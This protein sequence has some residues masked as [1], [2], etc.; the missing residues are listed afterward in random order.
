MLMMP[1]MLKAWKYNCTGS[2]LWIHSIATTVMWAQDV[3][4]S[5]C[6]IACV[7]MD[8]H[9]SLESNATLS[10]TCLTV[11]ILR[12]I[13][14][15]DRKGLEQTGLSHWVAHTNIAWSTSVTMHIWHKR[16]MS[17]ITGKGLGASDTLI[18]MRDQP[19]NRKFL[20]EFGEIS[21]G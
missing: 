20:V 10:A 13:T 19:L 14:D 16:N 9:S 17:V 21:Q 3:F 5:G 18:L 15:T 11:T 1:F 7:S 12:E 4:C 6:L 8:D 2:I